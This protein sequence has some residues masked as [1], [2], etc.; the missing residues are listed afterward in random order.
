MI[1]VLFPFQNGEIRLDW[2][3][4]RERHRQPTTELAQPIERDTDLVPRLIERHHVL[5]WIDDLFDVLVIVVSFDQVALLTFNL[6]DVLN[7]LFELKAIKT[8][9]IHV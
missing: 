4:V 1:V 9:L 3:R 7:L 8:R 6:V 5:V 2:R